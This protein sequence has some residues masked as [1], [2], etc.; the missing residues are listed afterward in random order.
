M[1]TPTKCCEHCI[2]NEV[3][4][5][6]PI[7]LNCKYGEKGCP[8]GCHNTPTR[9]EEIRAI[10]KEAFSRDDLG[11]DW[12]VAE[13]EAL[14]SLELARERQEAA[15]PLKSFHEEMGTHCE[16]HQLSGSPRCHACYLVKDVKRKLGEVLRKARTN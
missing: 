6:N 7:E 3:R 10:L 5:D 9:E 16:K 4:I 2:G 14:S 13:L 11:V 8:W 15:E 12:A 1:T